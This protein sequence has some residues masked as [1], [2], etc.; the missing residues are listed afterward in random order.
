M[1]VATRRPSPMASPLAC[2]ATDCPVT[3]GTAWSARISHYLLTEAIVHRAQETGD[4]AMEKQIENT[5]LSIEELDNV[6]GGIV[7]VG[8]SVQNQQTIALT[9]ELTAAFKATHQ[10]WHPPLWE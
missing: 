6:T 9:Q 10:H 7:P 8:L 4:R 3:W 2:A 5:E 1:L